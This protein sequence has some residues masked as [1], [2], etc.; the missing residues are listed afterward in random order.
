MP[1]SAFNVALAILSKRL[2]FRERVDG[3]EP[4]RSESRDRSVKELQ[5][6]LIEHDASDINGTGASI[7]QPS[8]LFLEHRLTCSSAP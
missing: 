6:Q 8:D 7:G 4:V 5:S 2:T 1:M 3:V